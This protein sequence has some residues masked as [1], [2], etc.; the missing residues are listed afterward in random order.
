MKLNISHFEILISNLSKDLINNKNLNKVLQIFSS[1]YNDNVTNITFELVDEII[2]PITLL[3][4]SGALYGE[5]N[6]SIY[7]SSS[8]FNLAFD[9]LT[10]KCLLQV[11]NIQPREFYLLKAIKLILSLIT[12]KCGGIPFHCSAVS[13]G[14]EGYIFTGKS[15]SGKT[16]AAVLLSIGKYQILNDEFNIILPVKN[17]SNYKIYSTPFTTSNKL[18]VC[19]NLSSNLDKIFFIN[20]AK[21]NYID[22][23]SENI[24]FSH[25]L[26]NVYTFPTTKSLSEKMLRNAELLYKQI[27][28]EQ[29]YFINNS[30]F[31]KDFNRIIN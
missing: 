20:Q 26:S 11:H 3:P 18:K 6:S 5:I 7:I 14:K 21:S 19:N 9:F 17:G 23:N 2:F 13:N 4:R 29:L 24:N 22:N 25:F 12:I 30:S 28:P 1:S 27:S 16:T 31:T 8:F 10:Q 15:G